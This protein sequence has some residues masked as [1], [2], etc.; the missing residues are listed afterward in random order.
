VT[1]ADVVLNHRVFLPV[2][3]TTASA[4]RK[5]NKFGLYRLPRTFKGLF[6]KFTSKTKSISNS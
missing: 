3:N 4:E 6:I 5:W 2:S 1:R